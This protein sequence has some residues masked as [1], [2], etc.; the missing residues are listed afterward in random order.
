MLTPEQV[1]KIIKE[2][3]SLK[4][5]D[6]TES[7]VENIIIPQ[8]KAVDYDWKSGMTKFVFIFPNTDFV[9]KLPFCGAYDEEAGFYE[10][11]GGWD[12]SWDYCETEMELYKNAIKRG[13]EKCFAKTTSI[14]AIDN[15]PLYMQEKAII[16]GDIHNRKD[17]EK[18]KTKLIREKCSNHKYYCCFHDCWLSDFLDYYGNTMFEQFMD[19]IEDYRIEDLHSDN[20]GYIDGRPVVVDYASFDH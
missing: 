18:E 10:F 13:V 11:C 8:M 16:W 2:N 15:Y 12:G 3:C 17:Y 9:I 1:Y 14:G 7:N 20:L 19:F 4:S 5:V 6:L